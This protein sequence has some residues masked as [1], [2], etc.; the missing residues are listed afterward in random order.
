MC[1]WVW[2]YILCSISLHTRKLFRMWASISQTSS[3]PLLLSTFS[4]TRLQT[5]D[6][7]RAGSYISFHRI[8][9]FYCT[10]QFTPLRL[11]CPWMGRFSLFYEIL[12]TFSEKPDGSQNDMHSS[13]HISFPL[14]L[15]SELKS[16]KAKGKI[17]VLT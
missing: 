2:S 6:Q 5:P 17:L 1:E 3:L 12:M 8:F 4:S 14:V 15:H 9:Q 16:L 10:P 11:K 13:R 7:Q